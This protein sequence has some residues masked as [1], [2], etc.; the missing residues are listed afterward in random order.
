MDEAL[1][2]YNRQDWARFRAGFADDLVVADHRPPPAVYDGIVGADKFVSTVQALFD[3]A[4][5][6]SVAA[7]ATHIV[8]DHSA[9]FDLRTT[10]VSGEASDFELAFHLAYVVESGKIN[11]LEFFPDDQLAEACATVAAS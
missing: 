2:A 7:V 11:R 3:L 10:G 4:S 1:T 6:V 8:N 5:G 9:V